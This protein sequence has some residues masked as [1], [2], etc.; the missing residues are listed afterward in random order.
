VSKWGFKY[1]FIYLFAGG[2]EG[3]RFDF[4]ASSVGIDGRV[5]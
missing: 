1:L 5:E 3:R 2:P 4:S